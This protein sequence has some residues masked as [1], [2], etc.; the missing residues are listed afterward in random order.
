MLNSTNSPLFFG[1]VA[2]TQLCKAY[3][4]ARRLLRRLYEALSLKGVNFALLGKR[5]PFLGF[6]PSESYLNLGNLLNSES[7]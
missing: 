1:K 2:V 5:S 3:F 4:S 6:S 7:S